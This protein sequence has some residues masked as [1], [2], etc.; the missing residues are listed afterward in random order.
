MILKS[1]SILT[2][3]LHFLIYSIPPLILMVSFGVIPEFE[4]PNIEKVIQMIQLIKI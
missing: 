2:G 1:D 3:I 4:D